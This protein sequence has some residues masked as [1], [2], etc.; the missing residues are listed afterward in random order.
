M[1]DAPVLA[2]APQPPQ[3]R[4]TTTISVRWGPP[5][6][7][8][9]AMRPKTTGAGPT[10]YALAAQCGGASANS[11]VA[12][13]RSNPSAPASRIIQASA[14]VEGKG[15]SARNTRA[16][17][18][19][20]SSGPSRK[21]V[22]V[23]F[24]RGGEMP[25]LNLSLVTATVGAALQNRGRSLK[26]L[27]TKPVYDSWSMSTSAV[28][29]T[30]EVEIIEAR[31]KEMVPSEF[32]NS[33]WVGL[34]TSTSYLK[35]LDVPY[36][37]TRGD[38]SAV[39]AEEVI[40]Q[41]RSSPL[42]EDLGCIS[43]KPRVVHNSNK[44]TTAMVYF[45]VFDSQTGTRAKRLIDRQLHIFG[46]SCYIR[47]AAS[48]PGT[49]H[50]PAL[51]QQGAAKGTQR[52]RLR[53]PP[54]RQAT[55]A[56]T[57]LPARTVREITPPLSGSA[58]FGD[59]ASIGNGLMINMPR[60]MRDDDRIRVLSFNVAKHH[61]YLDVI[62]EELNGRFDLLFIQE[63]PWSMIR[64]APSA[65]DPQGDP[66]IGMPIHPEWDCMVHHRTQDNQRP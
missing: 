8:N 44:S 10:M 39:T 18:S 42:R 15:R 6:R 46:R 27:S 63:P 25:S 35:V 34:P 32:R 47:A 29:T 52:L 51:L 9:R 21:Q 37:S 13:A 17:P 36:Y 50:L 48:N 41:F 54:L 3:Q 61:V 19:Y 58:P 23:S 55:R 45:N 24:P 64:R 56:H 14:V 11:I 4:G 20:T 66:V 28:A 65:R 16:T 5:P 49:P 7:V 2:A 53:F 38:R 33:L 30:P 57:G 60:L 43:G 22:L 26:V 40:E 12:L 59:T 1:A 31:I 62:L